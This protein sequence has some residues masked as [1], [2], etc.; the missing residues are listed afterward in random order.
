MW[1]TRPLFKSMYFTEKGKTPVAVGVIN[2][3]QRRPA[4]RRKG[5]LAET[6]KRKGVSINRGHPQ[7]V[8]VLSDDRGVNPQGVFLEGVTGGDQADEDVLPYMGGSPPP[9]DRP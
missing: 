3:S 8:A 7:G 6:H 1:C 9:A 2:K 5:V 4:V